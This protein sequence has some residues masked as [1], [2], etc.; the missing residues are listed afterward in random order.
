[1]TRRDVTALSDRIE[2]VARIDSAA[3]ALEYDPHFATAADL[4]LNGRT[5]LAALVTPAFEL[6]LLVEGSRAS[7]VGRRKRTFSE[8][9]T[10]RTPPAV[11]TSATS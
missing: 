6:E 9:V 1:M 8:R 3:K 5:A 7:G 10:P 4:R 11:P 2:A